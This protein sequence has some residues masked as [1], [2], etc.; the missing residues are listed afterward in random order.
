MT[1]YIE[2]FPEMKTSEKGLELYFYMQKKIVKGEEKMR[3]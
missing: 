1:K 3:T 2:E